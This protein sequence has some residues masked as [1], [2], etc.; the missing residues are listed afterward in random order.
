MTAKIYHG[1]FTPDALADALV[2]QFNR[3]A[4]QVQRI[5][6][7]THLAVQIAT[8]ENILAGG[9]TALTVNMEKVPDGVSVEISRQAWFGVAASLGVSALSAL[10]NPWNLLNR[11]DDIAQDVESLQLQENILQAIENFAHQ[12]GTG[13]ELSERLKRMVCPYCLTANPVGA[14]SCI[15]CGA[16]LGESQ[17]VTCPNCGFILTRQ[18]KVCPNC[19]QSLS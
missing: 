13:L 5:G 11:F 16:P 4:Y 2:A 18:E 12:H 1:E 19:G 15:A 10:R 6:D 8:R 7:G 3:G 17:P 14:S 9:P